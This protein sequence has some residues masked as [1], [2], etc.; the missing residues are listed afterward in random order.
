[1]L[2]Y[3]KLEEAETDLGR[4]LTMA[5]KLW[6]N[7]SAEKSDFLLYNHN[8]IFMILVFSLAP[9][10][11]AFMELSQSKKTAKFKIQ[12]NVKASFSD[13]FKCY[14]HVLKMLVFVSSPLL[15]LSFP[16]VKW[17]GI[18]TSLPLP[19]VWEILS[20]LLVYFLIEDYGSYWLHRLV[21]HS[22]WGYENIH[23]LHH[24]YTASFGFTAIYTHWGELLIFG[25]PTMLGPALVPCHTVTLY[26]WTCLRLVQAVDAH[27]G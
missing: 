2:P 19:S 5:E 22:K 17:L 25:I 26:L 9:L 12:P 6:Y 4:N 20:Q 10:P 27:N 23:Y 11:C 3:Q 7:Y 1:M 8:I 24:E 15:F 18:R 13:M 21:L 14:K 16:A